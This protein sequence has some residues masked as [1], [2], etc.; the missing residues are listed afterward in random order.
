MSHVKFVVQA[1][2]RSGAGLIMSALS[3]HPQCAVRGTAF[4]GD[5]PQAVADMRAAGSWKAWFDRCTEVSGE[6]KAAGFISYRYLPS[7]QA[8]LC[9]KW[10]WTQ[11]L[12][13][14]ISDKG[15]DDVRVVRITREDLITRAISAAVALFTG[16]VAARKNSDAL[17]H[18]MANQKAI[19][20]PPWLFRTFL[21]E[22]LAVDLLPHCRARTFSTTYEEF[23]ATWADTTQA[24]QKFL[25]VDVLQLTTPLARLGCVP[26]HTLIAN[27]DMLVDSFKS[28]RYEAYF[29]KYMLYYLP[30]Y[31]RQ[32]GDK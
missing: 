1:I 24:L 9:V 4:V 18:Y 17:R 3:R 21:D 28:T 20:V 30:L 15:S 10:E 2:P 5:T 6:R 11:T 7:A 23:I 14:Y 13:Q 8:G 31:V 25:G 29:E 19:D 26:P 27:W 16:T 12:W 22:G 32:S